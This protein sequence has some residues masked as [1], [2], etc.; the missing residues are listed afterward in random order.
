MLLLCYTLRTRPT[1]LVC[2]Q[3]NFVL[4]ASF[5]AG[6]AISGLIMLFSVQWADIKVEWWGNDQP[7]H[8]CEEKAC[9]LMTLAKG[10]RFYPWWDASKIPAP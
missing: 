9:T 10:Q 6:I 4:S 8:G 2:S 5:S 3:Y 7:F 1:N